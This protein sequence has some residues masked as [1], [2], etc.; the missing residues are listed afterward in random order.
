MI[1]FLLAV[2]GFTAGGGGG[3]TTGATFG[4]AGGGFG[5]Y[6]DTGFGAGGAADDLIVPVWTVSLNTFILSLKNF[7][8]QLICSSFC[9]TVQ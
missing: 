4:G 9:S 3:G 8:N 5:L 7:R 6:V 2:G 1:Y